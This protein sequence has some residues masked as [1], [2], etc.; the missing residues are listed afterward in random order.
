[1]VALCGRAGEGREEMNVQ[2]LFVVIMA[3][4]RH[5]C[6]G[7]FVYDRHYFFGSVVNF[8][9]VSFQNGRGFTNC[10]ELYYGKFSGW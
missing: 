4:A 2:K 1:M 6:L 9:V 10:G 5:Y 3:F 8:V 7:S